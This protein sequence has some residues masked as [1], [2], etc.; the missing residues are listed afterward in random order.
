M[1]LDVFCVVIASKGCEVDG[2]GTIASKGMT[3]LAKL[4][5]RALPLSTMAS[6]RI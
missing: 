1:S 5:N 3:H 4:S 2:C 6:S